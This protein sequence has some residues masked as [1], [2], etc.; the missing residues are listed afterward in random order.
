MAPCE[1]ADSGR[2]GAIVTI[3]RQSGADSLNGLYGGPVR[4]YD[5][6]E[7]VKMQD[8]NAVAIFK[9]HARSRYCRLATD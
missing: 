6:A 7:M 1:I 5:P 9:A 4:V 3:S 8:R 2:L